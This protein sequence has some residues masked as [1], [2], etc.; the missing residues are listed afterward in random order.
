MVAA[1][2]NSLSRF[3]YLLT[4][5]VNWKL[6][7]Y[8]N[9]NIKNRDFFISVYHRNCIPAKLIY[10]EIASKAHFLRSEY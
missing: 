9:G 1:H 8:L 6:N 7:I 4:E 10:F 2:G 5:Q 3:M